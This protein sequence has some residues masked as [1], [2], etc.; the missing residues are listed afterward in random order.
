MLTD[1]QKRKLTKL[2][3]M[4]D[5]D[6]DGFLHRQDYEN[7]AKKLA[8][9][10]GWGS[11]SAKYLQLE[12]QFAHNWKAL[13]GESN[14][15]R[16]RK[17]ALEEWLNHYDQILNNP[18]KYAEQMRTM[19]ELIFEVFDANGDGQISQD[20]WAGL[21]RVFNI[22]SVYAANVFAKLDTNSDG[23][24][25]KEEVIQLYHNFFYSNQPDA[26]GNEM[27]GPY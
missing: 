5:A 17:V 6:C 3:S 11:R 2:F 1:I 9:L 26:P 24:L 14:S 21:L 16:D 18:D 10:R 4:Y 22:S 7:V 20:E 8:S 15:N 27:F 19:M 12:S 13:Q 23:V 25:N